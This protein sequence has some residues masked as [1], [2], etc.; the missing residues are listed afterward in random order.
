MRLLYW[1][2]LFWPYVGGPELFAR[3]LL[4]ALRGRGYEITVVTSH[5]HLDLTDRS[6]LD[7]IPVHRFPMRA[8][9]ARADV[10]GLADVA[11]RI[12]RL[13]RDVAPDLI[14]ISGV[15]P[16]AVFHLMTE[17]SHPAPLL[18]SLRTEVLGSQRERNGS[19]LERI[20]RRAQWTT[21]VSSVVLEQARQ[22]VPGVVPR[23]SVV[24]N[25]VDAPDRLATA[26]PF[27]PPRLLCLGRLIPDKG[28]DLAVKALPAV[29]ARHSRARMTIAGD[30]PEQGNLG[31]LARDLGVGHAVDLVGPIAPG[32]VPDLLDAA[33][34]VLV[35][36]RREGLPMVAIEAAMMARPV[37]AARTG[38]LPEALVDGQTGLLVPYEDVNALAEAIGAL[39]DQPA[40]ATD[41]GRRA[42]ERVRGVFAR[43][44]CVD[45]YVRVYERLGR[46]GRAAVDSAADGPSEEDCGHARATLS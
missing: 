1:S 45:A 14:H 41:I 42:R 22:L 17:R 37:V 43:E 39:L 4:P 3:R 6:E 33:T 25:F 7:G 12:E 28:F 24:Y 15:G 29:L 2:E 27:D 38:G 21:A 44:R 13:K 18:V 26:P 8:A 34:L 19:L 5:D 16:S 9:L 10:N 46:T 30:G 20:L 40:V 36:S 35:P 31:R 23:S 11:G 32:D